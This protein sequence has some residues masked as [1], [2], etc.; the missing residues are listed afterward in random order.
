MNYLKNQLL[1]VDIEYKII[2]GDFNGG[3]T[4]K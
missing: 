3:V 4:T 1:P 2:V